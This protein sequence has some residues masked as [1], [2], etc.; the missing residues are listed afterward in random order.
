MSFIA[1][2]T[3]ACTGIA[4]PKY[5]PSDIRS[6]SDIPAIACWKPA[7]IDRI[8]ARLEK[9]AERRDRARTIAAGFQ[10]AMA[11]MSEEELHAFFTH[12]SIA[13]EAAA[14]LELPEVQEALAELED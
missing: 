11:G 13:G 8:D 5:E 9:I 10:Q 12:V 14:F 6:S 3:L 4:R 7:A 1:V 2:A